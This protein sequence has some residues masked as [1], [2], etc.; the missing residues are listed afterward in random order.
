VTT[1]VLPR[2]ERIDVRVVRVPRHEHN[3]V[4]H[5]YGTTPD[6]HYALVE[7]LAEGLVGLGEAPTEI[8]W[9]GEDAESVRW[10]I[11]TH[12]APAL[13]GAD[14][15]IR[16]AVRRM[17][18]AMHGNPYAKA[19]IQ[20]A[21]WDLL[22]KRADLPLYALLGGSGPEPV[23]VKYGVGWGDP[24]HVREEIAHGRELG[25]RFFKLK[26]G[27]ALERD[28]LRTRAAVDALRDGEA[29]GVDANAGW[30][31][32]TAIRALRPLEELGI[33][34]LEQPVARDVP[35]AMAE[36]ARRSAIP[37]M[38][39]E[40]LGPVAQAP[41]IAQL[42]AAHLWSLTPSMHGG[43]VQTGEMLAIAGAY[44]L[45]CLFGSTFELGV[46]TA[47][48]LHLGAAYAAIREC[49]VPS[50]LPGPLYVERDIVARPI[51]VA[52]GFAHVPDGPGLGVELDEDFVAACA[53]A[54]RAG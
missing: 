30:T 28:L 41:R 20:M 9:T 27:Q 37:V 16:D 44:S 25:F 11:E 24:G 26:V 35:E 49:P 3:R 4:T 18:R 42:G 31:L 54:A 29:I 15:G 34:F 5:A 38:I 12:L 19:A 52:D 48:M 6:A 21:L 39:H 46:A 32:A 33:A 36:V 7:V 10:A 45:P 14:I 13:I 17:D 40:G 23:P 1:A 2:I 53:D 50:D 51:V 22:G 43:I 47:H 8:W